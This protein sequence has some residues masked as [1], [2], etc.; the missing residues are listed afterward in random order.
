[1][2]QVALSTFTNLDI[3]PGAVVENLG[4]LLTFNFELDEPARVGGLKIYVDS[5]TPGILGRL[6]LSALNDNPDFLSNLT[7]NQESFENFTGSGFV[8]TVEAGAKSASLTLPALDIADL[9]G[10]DLTTFTLTTREET[11]RTTQTDPVTGDQGSDLNT[12]EADGFPIGDYT[13]DPESASS[14]VLFA[15]NVADLPPLP[16][17]SFSTT[18][19]VV[20][21]AEG[22]FLVMDFSVEGEIPDGGVTVNLEGDAA[23]I[24]EQ[25]DVVQAGIDQ[26][27]GNIF[28]RFDEDFVNSDNIVG[29]ILD[30]FSLEDGD[31][32]ENN[33]DP[34]AAGDAF[35]SSFSFTITEN[36][37][38][39][40]LPVLDDFVQEDDA[41]FTY[42][43]ALESAVE[44]GYLV[45][46]DVNSGTFTLTDGVEPATSPTIGVTVGSTTLIRDEQTVMELTFTSE[47]DIPAEG[48][49]VLLEGP[50]KGFAEFD[51]SEPIN[52]TGGT[53]VGTDDIASTL[54]LLIT[55]P[56]ATVE[57]PVLLEE[58]GQETIVLPF[59]LIDGEQYEIDPE[60]SAIEVTI[61]DPPVISLGL[62][63]GTFNGND[64]IVPHLV[65]QADG[66]PI[67]SVVLESDGTIPE[68]GLI[69]DVNTDL[70]D[71]TE[72]VNE[73]QFNPIAFGGQVISA[74]YD[75]AGIAT[76]LR[77][78]MDDPNTVVNFQNGVGFDA[79]GP[80][81]VSFF[82]EEGDRY[83]STGEAASIT[84]YDTLDQVPPPPEPL[85]EVGV[86]IAGGGI[87]QQVPPL[88]E[89]EGD[90][91]LELTVEG[92]IPTDG[93]ITYLKTDQEA[94]LGE[95]DLLNAEV[96][97]GL[98]PSPDGD[99][100]GFY[101]KVTEPTA[102]ITVQAAVDDIEEGIE[103]I[104]FSL[105]S[106]PGYTIDDD[107]QGI[108]LELADDEN[109]K[110]QVSIDS[111]PIDLVAEE[112]TLATITLNLS[113]PPPAI[114]PIPSRDGTPPEA[115]I[116]ITVQT[117]GLQEF[118]LDS[119]TATGGNIVNVNTDTGTIDIRALEQTVTITATVANDG[120][121]EGLET[122]LFTLVEPGEDADYQISTT[123]PEQNQVS[124][125]IYNTLN[126][127]PVRVESAESDD[128]IAT[129]IPIAIN[130]DRS[131]A[132]VTGEIDFNF[133]NNRDVDQTEDVDMYS[134]QLEAGDRLVV[135]LDS[136]ASDDGEEVIPGH[137]RLFDAAG[138]DL[139]DNNPGADLGEGLVSGGNT[140]IDFTADTAGT[141]YI[142]VSQ[143]FNGNYDPNNKGT[144][145]GALL[146]L[147]LG[148]GEYELKVDLNIEPPDNDSVVIEVP[149]I[150]PGD[151]NDTTTTNNDI[152]ASATPLNFAPDNLSITV[153]AEIAERFQERDNAVDATEDV[154]FYSF[155]LE[156]GESITIDVDANGIGDAGLGSILDS[157]LLIFEVD[158]DQMTD[159]TELA[160][161][162]NDAAPDEIFQAE[163]DP[164]IVFTAPETGT[165]YAGISALGNDF[166]DPNLANS[167]SGW[168]FGERFG[169]DIYRVNFS[170]DVPPLPVVSIEVTPPSVLE[171]GPDDTGTVAFTVDG[172]VP[173]V[174][175]DGN[176]DY[177]S[178]GLS[179]FLD[180]QELDVLEVQFED[181]VGNELII[182]PFS[183]PTQPGVLEFILFD[184]TASASFTAIDDD[185][186]EPPIPFEFTLLEDLD[187]S[188]YLVDTDAN[189][190]SLTLIDD[191]PLLPTVSIEVDETELIEGDDVTF[192]L[193][194]Q[195]GL[196]SGDNPVT[197]LV[198][199]DTVGGL[200]EF[201]LFDENNNPLFTTVGIESVSILDDETNFSAVLI[202]PNASITFSVLDDGIE[203][204]L[205]QFTYT[206]ADGQAD[207]VVDPNAES[208]TI[209]IDDPI[210]GGPGADIFDAGLTPGF[211]GVND[212]V[213]A[214]EGDDLID[215]NGGS[216][217]NTLYGE[218]NNDTF[219]LRS[220]DT[221][222]GGEGEDS[223]FLLRGDNIITGGPGADE[224]WLVAS[225]IPESVN[226]I[227][228]FNDID[229]D[230]LGIASLDFDQLTISDANG[231][232]LIAAGG[233]PFARLIGVDANS[234]SE[235]NFI[236]V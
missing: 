15:D 108:S 29:G 68:G 94:G 173:D 138:A 190:G 186:P 116:L 34:E 119:L 85:P 130:S 121:A 144:G 73:P 188:D 100:E 54:S 137:L 196:P 93:V 110:I 220:N 208:V 107:A 161:S 23:R 233:N 16:V 166:Y 178:G 103:T 91:T 27:T 86:T 185:V 61:Q 204:G 96:V 49:V 95:F 82:V 28:Y 177:V 24:M 223:F 135:D 182:G 46:P 179:V 184:E 13:V 50:P 87:S 90:I 167:G 117:D 114:K 187:G 5:D 55:D 118:N 230:V 202:D 58:E 194:S 3:Y 72:L 83:I 236:I 170:L 210:I 105:Q 133:G 156:A 84:V 62:L 232:T 226:I 122:V 123:N 172:E 31:P 211:D 67:L 65:E 59:T 154:D 143:T 106:V 20:N 40:R 148:I 26:E 66:I 43:P 229:G 228:D 1:M 149:D 225:D 206:L 21:E 127:S 131:S 14:R 201:E 203:E 109:S 180:I 165:Y 162:N 113:S 79:T 147:G 35:L 6:D 44:S 18:P 76:G 9:N 153:D 42:S 224:F 47:G 37:A 80:Q 132:I 39:I 176:G 197:I 160:R 53:I 8:V 88:V 4:T 41:T 141:Y 151:P 215:T 163:G 25:F 97:G 45:D 102:T 146:D 222:F 189:S 136:I 150:E 125:D 195:G 175:F 140:L 217:G 152:I 128:T 231:D 48:V 129:S 57:L 169:A 227:N 112:E 51:F 89:G 98:F 7:V 168:T 120:E 183:D 234:L 81:T 126:E 193:I 104:D 124:F 191:D 200:A 70:A 33:S 17:V 115:G 213:F 157:I 192:S 214:R 235:D 99:G 74:I 212:T 142:G 139:V 174:E 64:L 164:F 32:A 92:E 75:E 22:T 56:T 199:G 101:F 181:F 159:V 218:E 221:A 10:L 134:V 155:N 30:P 77:V 36:T 219:I 19:Q 69:V 209:T 78:R 158:D 207:Y 60:A 52:I 12:V 198:N 63:G 171:G 216:G 11:D 205:E 2:P 145:D 38:S 71:I 111:S